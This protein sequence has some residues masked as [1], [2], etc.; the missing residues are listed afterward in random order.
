MCVSVWRTHT[1]DLL[2]LNDLWNSPWQKETLKCAWIRLVV[3]HASGTSFDAGVWVPASVNWFRGRS[4][5]S[6]NWPLLAQIIK[7]AAWIITSEWR[8]HIYVDVK[9][10]Y[11]EASAVPSRWFHAFIGSECHRQTNKRPVKWA[12]SE[13]AIIRPLCILKR[14][15]AFVWFLMHSLACQCAFFLHSLHLHAGLCADKS[16]AVTGCNF[17]LPPPRNWIS[18]R[19]IVLAQCSWLK[20]WQ[21]SKLMSLASHVSFKQGETSLLR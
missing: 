19:W 7:A 11:T 8:Q 1:C 4:R 5:W 2:S 20:Q 12:V 21:I 14:S 13:A 18:L 6:N 17:Q 10:I 9:L 15:C 16:G 3:L